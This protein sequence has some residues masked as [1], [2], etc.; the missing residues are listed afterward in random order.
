[1]F[2]VL[3]SHSRSS[4]RSRHKYWGFLPL[5]LPRGQ[6]ENAFISKWKHPPATKTGARG[7]VN[8]PMKGEPRHRQVKSCEPPQMIG[9]M[10]GCRQTE[11]HS[12]SAE[13]G[14]SSHDISC[15]KLNTLVALMSS[16]LAVPSPGYPTKP[17]CCGSSHCSSPPNRASRQQVL[18]VSL[19][20]LAAVPEQGGI[21]AFIPPGECGKIFRP[22]GPHEQAP[23]RGSSG[24]HFVQGNCR[25]S[26]LYPAT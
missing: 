26:P 5:C 17:L 25:A 20:I 8:R 4:F 24:P 14:G 19:H 21:P 18:A 12:E 22:Q 16:I 23:F 6:I 9:A 10:H 2:R 7:L 13:P 11:V 3:C 15:L 1:M